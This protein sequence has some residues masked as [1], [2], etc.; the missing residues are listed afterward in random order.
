MH[1]GATRREW[2][3]NG[4]SSAPSAKLVLSASAKSTGSSSSN[5]DTCTH[6]SVLTWTVETNEIP[7]RLRITLFKGELV[8]RPSGS[9]GAGRT[10]NLTFHF[11]ESL[12]SPPPLPRNARCL[13]LCAKQGT[14]SFE[15]SEIEKQEGGASDPKGVSHLFS[16]IQ[17]LGLPVLP[18]RLGRETCDELSHSLFQ[19]GQRALCA[20]HVG[21]P[22]PLL[23]V[24]HLHLPDPFELLLCHVLTLEDAPAQGFSFGSE[25]SFKVSEGSWVRREGRSEARE[26]QVSRLGGQAFS[27]GR[28]ACT[29]P[30]AKAPVG[31][32]SQKRKRGVGKGTQSAVV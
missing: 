2:R 23:L 4:A 16:I 6:L 21:R 3:A 8:P 28:L 31:G 5:E 14:T 11:R 18:G 10:W 17:Q 9:S 26:R 27:G 20:E 15:G 12:K 1:A 30:C 19:S 24:A 7:Y 29:Y 13:V 22:P 25:I 32:S